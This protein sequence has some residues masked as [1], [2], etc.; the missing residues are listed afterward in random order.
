M[1]MRVVACLEL[2]LRSRGP[3]FGALCREGVEGG[4]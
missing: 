4:L 3:A 2:G 1:M